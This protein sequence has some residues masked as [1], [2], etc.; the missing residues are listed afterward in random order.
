MRYIK[1][2][3]KIGFFITVNLCNVR[4]MCKQCE[5]HTLQV[6]KN[7]IWK[8]DDNIMFVDSQTA[9][10]FIII[11]ISREQRRVPSNGPVV[12]IKIEFILYVSVGYHPKRDLRRW[13]IL[14]YI[15]VIIIEQSVKCAGNCRTF[16]TADW[17]G[18]GIMSLSSWSL[19][20][21]LHRNTHVYI[22]SN[23]ITR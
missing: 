1:K 15:I 9:T 6:G 7:I 14:Y 16:S 21:L 19:L 17:T 3:L 10:L 18:D 12:H 11:R 23:I 5:V 2:F 4:A 20:L 22:Y 13:S 8:K